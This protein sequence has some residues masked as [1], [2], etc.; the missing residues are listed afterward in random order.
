MHIF[1]A[2]EKE[3]LQT[4]YDKGLFHTLQILRKLTPA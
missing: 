1:I 3:K 4:N 2:F